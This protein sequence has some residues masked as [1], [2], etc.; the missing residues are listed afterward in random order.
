MTRRLEQ[1]GFRV[2]AVLGDYQGG[3]WDDRADVWMILA[4]KK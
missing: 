4:S 2:R 3:P 1:A